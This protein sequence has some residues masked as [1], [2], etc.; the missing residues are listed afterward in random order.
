MHRTPSLL[1]T[2][3]AAAFLCLGAASAAAQG[4]AGKPLMSVGLS[5]V[6]INVADIARAR[7]GELATLLRP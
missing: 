3:L 6:G 5:S 1:A 4:P 7:D 2:A